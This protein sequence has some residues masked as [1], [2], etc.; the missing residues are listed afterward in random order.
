MWQR[1]GLRRKNR[2]ARRCLRRRKIDLVLGA[3]IDGRPQKTGEW[4]GRKKEGICLPKD[5][6][7]ER[8]VRQVGL[9]AALAMPLWNI[10]LIRHILKRKS[11]ADISR[12]WLYGVWSCIVLMLPSALASPDI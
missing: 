5:G 1:S 4:R 10:P 12:G 6:K 8:F 7:M 11:S 9:V 2:S 3:I